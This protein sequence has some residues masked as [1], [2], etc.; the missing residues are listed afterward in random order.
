MLHVAGDTATVGAE[1]AG[2][3]DV[4]G[5][6]ASPIVNFRQPPFLGIGCDEAQFAREQNIGCGSQ[7]SGCPPID[8]PKQDQGAQRTYAGNGERPAERRG[9]DEIRQAHGE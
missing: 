2:D 8:E 4:P 5:I 3:P 7:I 6:M 1:E 9:P